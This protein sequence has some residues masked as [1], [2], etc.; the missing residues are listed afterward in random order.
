M[1]VLLSVKGQKEKNTIVNQALVAWAPFQ[2][3]VRRYAQIAT[4][5]FVQ[6]ELT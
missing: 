5:K 4:F 2:F 3:E 6:T 1:L